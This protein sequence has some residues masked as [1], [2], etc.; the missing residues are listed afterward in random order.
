[1]L[2]SAMEQNNSL[3][4][5]P[6]NIKSKEQFDELCKNWNWLEQYQNIGHCKL[7]GYI[8]K[9]DNLP[10]YNRLNI[11]FETT[12][13][14]QKTSIY[15]KT[16]MR[17]IRKGWPENK[18]DIQDISYQQLDEASDIFSLAI[19]K[20]GIA[21][22]ESIFL[23]LPRRPELYVA[24][25]GTLKS[26]AVLSPLFSAFGPEPA[27]TRINKGHGKVLISLVSLYKKKIEPI[28]N[29][30]ES[31]KYIILID[32]TD[33]LKN[34]P[35]VLD[36]H[37]L[38]NTTKRDFFSNGF[39]KEPVPNTSITDDALIHFTSGTTGK[40]KGAVHIHGAVIYHAVTGRLAL[41]IQPDDIFWCTADPGWVTGM[42]YGIISPLVNGATLI[43]D[44]G[45]FQAE[46]WYQIL[47]DMKVTNWY[48][49]PTALRMLMKQGEEL[50]KVYNLR[51]LRFVASVGEPLNPEVV[52]WAKRALNILIHDNW[53][54]TET[55]GIAISNFA[56]M[57]VKPGSMGK[58]LPGMQIELARRKEDGGLE[59]ILEPN[60][61]GEIVLQKNWP[62]MFRNYLGDDERYK[63]CFVGDWYL[64]GDLAYKDK[65]GYFWFVGRS[66]DVIKSSG[67]LIGPF[68]IES[69]LLEHPSVAEAGVIGKPD[70][71]AG[72]IVKAFV[73]LKKGFSFSE[74]L[75]SE[76]LGQTR[77]KLG[78]AVAP[79]EL[80][81]LDSLPKTRS[82]K[83]M[84]RLLKAR[85]LN[86]PEGDISTLEL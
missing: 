70:P 64:S 44:E 41:D 39:S 63:K 72:E 3:T 21:K 50:P 86:L 18:L 12:K 27:A 13:R 34:I 79:R 83:I 37:Q 53:W 29:S 57:E 47:Q 75:K 23:L 2:E 1:M 17:F 66:D 30:L 48:T 77:K 52:L 78:P 6:S 19:E 85:E 45:E 51:N 11:G 35:N 10:I 59:F 58:P 9:E 68:E 32:D 71:I 38:M 84:R 56:F 69:V 46:R 76:I 55:G 26:G 16:A 82:G 61:Q 62:A 22:G 65:D 31:L 4:L 81:V 36:F 67:H 5:K 28:R 40:P 49:A 7:N 43:I 14:H 24:A 25:L 60:M 15:Q 8:R 54:Q 20:L 33:D 74:A 42:S 73:S 80:S